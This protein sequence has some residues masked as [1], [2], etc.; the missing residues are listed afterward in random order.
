[1]SRR[2]ARRTSYAMRAL[3]LGSLAIGGAAA[4]SC[5][6]P[7]TVSVAI[8]LGSEEDAFS[9]DPAVSRVDLVAESPDGS[10]VLKASAAPGGTFELG[11]AP[12]TA[13][14]QFNL[15]G[16]T[17]DETVVARGRSV[18]VAIGAYPYDEL[19][20]FM[21]RRMEFARPPNGLVRAHVHAP[22][23]VLLE[24]YLI[25]TGGEN[26]VGA[27]GPVDPA[28]GDFYDMLLFSGSESDETLPRAARSMVVRDKVVVL[29]DDAGATSQDLDSGVATEVEPPDGFTFAEVS[30]G[31]A[32]DNTSEASTPLTTYV[33]GGTRADGD[34]T[35]A[36]LVVDSAG[37]ISVV[38]L[39][40]A[41][42]GASALYVPDVGLVIVGGAATGAGIEV[43]ADGATTATA[44]AFPADPTTGAAA[45]VS[46]E[47]QIALLGGLDGASAPQ[48]TRVLDLRCVADCGAA[49]TQIVPGAAL[50]DLAARGHAYATPLGLLTIGESADGETLAFLVELGASSVTPLPLKQR[51]WGATPIPAPN[52]TL[53]IVGG[54]DQGGGAA[55][56]IELFFPE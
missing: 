13:I 30:G 10:V 15:Q 24:R 51:R 27:D 9:R 34:P 45:A 39:A 2:P 20:L 32:I 11:D 40:T 3:A 19:P 17:D 5:D 12:D 31:E 38:R 55:S 23:G 14:L 6:D 35:D 29:I 26:A 25:A 53:A 36:V 46:G 43:I 54:L 8:S 16:V 49:G 22:A 4:S 41:R 52:G 50:P 47:E 33:V 1:M 48:A 37:T 28:F 18:S 56:P 21:Q 42:L 7:R 44:L